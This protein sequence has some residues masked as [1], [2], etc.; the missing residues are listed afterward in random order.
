MVKPVP[1]RTCLACRQIKSK[2]EMLRIV[3][4]PEGNIELDAS[5]KREGRGAY[6]CTNPVCW[7]KIKKDKQLEHALK[8][9][10]TP[11]NLKKIFENG[12]EILKESGS[13]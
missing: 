7:D 1:Q 6:I 13:G 9:N 8:S 12:T 4:T 5:G 3:R 2:R 10:I 11:D